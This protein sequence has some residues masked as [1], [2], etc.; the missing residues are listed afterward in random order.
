MIRSCQPGD[1]DTIYEI[2]NDA[3][4]AYRGVIP[5]DCWSEPYM[6]REALRHEIE[7][8]VSFWGVE[9]GE[10]LVAVMGLQH[11]H[12][13]ALIRHAYTRRTH[14]HSG[15]GSALLSHFRERTDRP[16]LIGTW[17]AA[18]WAIRFYQRH[19]FRLVDREAVGGLLRRYWTVSPRQIAESVVL[20]DERGLALV[21]APARGA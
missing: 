1:F 20:A 17:K 6:S 9:D 16:I 14:Q 8:G 21:E 11:V 7:E 19:G 2:I 15:H 5:P 12:D 3:A 13:V 10:H 18:T 4:E